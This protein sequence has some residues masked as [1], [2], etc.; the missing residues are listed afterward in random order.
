MPTDNPK[1]ALRAAARARRAAAHAAFGAR[2]GPV[3]AANFFQAFSF[4]PSVLVAGYAPMNTE[5]DVAPL[6]A[7]L[8]ARGH[9]TALPAMTGRGAALAFRAW[10]PGAPLV[11]GIAGIAEPPED[12]PEIVPELVLVPLL[13]YDAAGH[14]LG[15]G[16]GYYDRTIAALRARGSVRAVGI[17][18]SAQAVDSLPGAAH[19]QRLDAVLTELGVTRFDGKAVP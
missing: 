14:R 1:R 19:D 8:A 6:M 12:A 13:A 3:L 15:Y 11:P 7:A 18:F 17:A 5:A 2:I 4:P 9:A 16:G 10:H